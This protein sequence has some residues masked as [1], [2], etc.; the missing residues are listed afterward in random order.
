M[1]Q[2]RHW[3]AYGTFQREYDK[4]AKTVDPALVRTWPSRAQLHR[5][6]SGTI[7]GLPYPDHCRVLE[8]MFPG[9]TAHDLF[10]PAP[11]DITSARPQH[12]PPQQP[13]ALP[14]VVPPVG[15]RPH[16]ERAFERQHV[17]IDFAGF[18]GETLQGVIQEPLDKI[19]YGQLKPESVTIRLLLPD[20]SK[21]MTLPCKAEDLT[22]DPD[23]RA[24]ANT[25]MRRHATAIIDSVNELAARGAVKEAAARIRLHQVAPLFKLYLINGEHAFFGFYPI[26]EYDLKVNGE[27][28]TI[29]DLMGKDAMMFHHST[30]NDAGREYIKQSRLWFDSIWNTISREYNG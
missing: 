18:S 1:L 22:D 5:W 4:A 2:Q 23:F 15:L 19:R 14:A 26:A 30:D 11:E 29:Y 28:R 3:Q 13:E 24:R 27:S 7:K 16:L 21:P 6:L 17:S 8:A 25:I 9:W 10:A 20:T 12:S